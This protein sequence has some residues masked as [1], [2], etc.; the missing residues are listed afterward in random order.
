MTA[1]GNSTLVLTLLAAF[2]A[3][4]GYAGGRLHQ[5]YRMGRDRDEAYRDGY[6]TATRSV[7]S[8][9][10]RVITPRRADRPTIRAAASAVGSTSAVITTAGLPAGMSSPA[11]PPPLADSGPRGAAV[12]HSGR[13]GQGA[14]AARPGDAAV[15]AFARPGQAPA[16]PVAG[17]AAEGR[18]VTSVPSF[19]G[20]GPSHWAE[21]SDRRATPAPGG[22]PT[23]PPDAAGTDG[24]A[25]SPRLTGQDPASKRSGGQPVRPG[26]VGSLL[27]PASAAGGPDSAASSGRHFVPD[28]LVQAATYRLPA[29]RVARAKVRGAVPSKDLP[30]VETQPRSPVPKPRSS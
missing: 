18:P 30:T 27:P 4:T 12:A 1:P 3:S 19:S 15:L 5:W 11:A 16:T 8:L 21:P 9:A 2:I 24:D 17:D 10:A 28:E 26:A 14:G 29:D 23:L 13:G 6:D 20:N 22:K 25:S 7:F